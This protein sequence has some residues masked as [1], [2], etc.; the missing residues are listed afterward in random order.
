MDPGAEFELAP[1][2]LE[3]LRLESNTWDLL[4]ALL[5]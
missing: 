3:I 5:P 2:T 4:Q 1:E